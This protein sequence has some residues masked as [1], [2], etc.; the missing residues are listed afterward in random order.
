M[1]TNTVLT[2]NN[3]KTFGTKK[4][5]TLIICKAKT[6]N[7]GKGNCKHFDHKDISIEELKK[8]FIKRYNEKA[9]EEFYGKE[10]YMFNSK[11]KPIPISHIQI[12]VDSKGRILSKEELEAGASKIA[13][14]FSNN[15]W[16][17]IQDF[18][19]GYHNRLTDEK[20]RKQFE[21]DASENILDYLESDDEVAVKVRE[22]LGSKINLK[23][24]SGILVQQVGS[25]TAEYR[26]KSGRASVRR[27]ILSSFDNDMTKERYIASVLFFGGKCCYCNVPLQKDP[28]PS[29]QASGE[30][31][32]PVSPLNKEDIAGSTRYGNMALACIRCNRD[33]ENK[34]L[35]T[36][37]QETRCINEEDKKNTLGKIKAFRN[38]ALYSD[39]S[40]EENDEINK[41]VDSMND[42]I[43]NLR[44][45][46]G[47]VSKE[48][49]H[50]IKDQF[51]IQIHDLK[52]GKEDFTELYFEN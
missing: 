5:G 42:F 11:G 12:Q 15:D 7:R 34:E 46:N 24:F 41:T 3:I 17:F 43:S 47:Y 37:M 33:R 31:L 9:L 51:K 14:S 49:F 30:H 1:I 8:G 52:H 45:P 20:F 10:G 6:E 13:H 23:N 39:Y 18:Y 26:W 40:E 50:K 44:E 21:D 22:F 28:P 27:V 16:K 4:D 36:W 35:I 38:F 19:K 29:K 48:N 2:K 25:M 32:T